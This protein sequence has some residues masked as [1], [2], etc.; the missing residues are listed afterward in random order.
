MFFKRIPLI[1]VLLVAGSATSPLLAGPWEDTS[2]LSRPV[3]Y[4]KLPN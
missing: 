1:A 2:T 3:Q 4:L